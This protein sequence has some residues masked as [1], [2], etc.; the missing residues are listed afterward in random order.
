MVNINYSES[1]TKVAVGETK[2]VKKD[3]SET[4]CECYLISDPTTASA[5]YFLL[6]DR[7][8]MKASAVNEITKSFLDQVGTISGV[9]VLREL[10]R[11]AYTGP[12][13]ISS[14]SDGKLHLRTH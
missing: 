4:I 14:L 2:N 10:Y 13:E 12:E 6:P 5:F 9:I 3:K 11:T 1:W 8:G 7:D